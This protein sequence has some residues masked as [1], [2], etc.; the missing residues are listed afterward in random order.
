[1]ILLGNQV[2][3]RLLKIFTSFGPIS[4]LCIHN[5]ISSSQVYDVI[6]TQR[7]V[8]AYDRFS[9]SFRR[10]VWLKL[11]PHNNLGDTINRRS[12]RESMYSIV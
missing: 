3:N 1:M 4:T 10:F 12:E 8:A 11:M 9:L 7:A 5:F 2:K 6:N